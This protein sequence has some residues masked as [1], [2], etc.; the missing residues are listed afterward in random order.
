MERALIICDSPKATD[1][2]E[3]FL[4]AYG[5]SWIIVAQDGTHAKEKLAMDDYEICI[6]HYPLRGER[7]V[8]SVLDIAEKN[9][10]QVILFAKE[11]ILP[12][13]LDAVD[14]SGVITLGRPISK[15]LFRSALMMSDAV[16]V[17]MFRAQERIA[18]LEKQLREAKQIA[19]A[20][21][22]LIE[23]KGIS[24]EEAHRFIEKQAMDQRIGRIEIAEEIIDF[25]G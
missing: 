16:A 21:C 20:K 1:F 18:R 4:K 12:D 14:Q 7:G 10:C 19:R 6:I 9:V 25:Y 23:R 15:G 2:Y 3:S 5:A 13:V 11:E 24:E 22:L 17:R 8:K